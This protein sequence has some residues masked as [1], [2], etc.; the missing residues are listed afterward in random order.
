MIFYFKNRN[1]TIKELRK[2]ISL[3]AQELSLKIKCDISEILSIENIQLKELSPE[4]KDKL[5]PI[6]REDCYGNIRW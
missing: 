2:D 4:M 3:T 6:F 1:K 5:I